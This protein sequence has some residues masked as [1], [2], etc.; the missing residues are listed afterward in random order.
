VEFNFR[1]CTPYPGKLVRVAILYDGEPTDFSF[2][3]DEV[4]IVARKFSKLIETVARDQIQRIPAE[5]EN[6]GAE[7]DIVNALNQVDCVDETKS[8]FTKWTEGDK[9]PDKIGDYK[10]VKLVIDASRT[11][12][13]EIFRPKGWRI[14]LIVSGSIKAAWEENGGTGLA[15]RKATE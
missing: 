8:R 3:S 11:R 6:H 2:A 14:S 7:Y 13:L 5:I 12:D 4:P 15:F 9:R 10:M 1:S